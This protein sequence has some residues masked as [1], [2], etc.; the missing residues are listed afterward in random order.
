MLIKED[1]IRT[2]IRKKLLE[3]KLGALSFNLNRSGGGSSSSS[4][5]SDV[6]SGKIRG[7]YPGSNVKAV[8]GALKNEGFTNKFFIIGVLC[9]VAK[10]SNFRPQE[11]MM[12]KSKSRV[13]EVF[14]NNKIVCGPHSGKMV[15][16]LSD[17]EL[18]QI[19]S[20]KELF[21]NTIYGG[22]KSLGNNCDGDGFR[23]IGRGF[24]QLTGRHNYRKYGY[25]NNPE[26]VNNAEDAAIVVARF[27]KNNRLY[28]FD[29]MNSANTM[30]KGINMAADI[31]SGSRNKLGG[32]ARN[33]AMARLADFKDLV[34]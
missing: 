16:D 27:M 29:E 25:E 12:Y 14:V 9:V 6:V 34:V 21:F 2:H 3:F 8:I 4:S 33:N 15:I 1:K 31:N 5:L 24:N 20:S 23:Y 10:E 13:R 28:S 26:A 30:R 22:R 7:N 32:R 17:E 18:D 11:E 19:M